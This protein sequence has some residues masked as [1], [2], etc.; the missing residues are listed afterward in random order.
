M[1]VF[2]GQRGFEA[3]TPDSGATVWRRSQPASGSSASLAT[4]RTLRKHP[5]N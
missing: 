1:V 3:A 5:S 4:L 2:I